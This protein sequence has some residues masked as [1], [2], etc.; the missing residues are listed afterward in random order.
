MKTRNRKRLALGLAFLAP[1]I[2]GF[3]VF[4]LFPLIFSMVLALTNSDLQLHNM[5]KS[6]MPR[7]IGVTNFIRLWQEPDFWRYLGNTLFLMLGIP[8]SIAG[9][10]VAAILLSQDLKGGSRRTWAWVLAGAVM[11]AGFVLMAL[12]G[13]GA[14]A[15]T[16]LIVSV[17]MGILVL[18]SIGG[19]TVYRTLFFT[20]HFTSGVATFI[21]WKK[22]YNPQT[23][24]INGALR[25]VL[26]GLAA[27]VNSLPDA[28]FGGLAWLCAIGVT[29]AIGWG[30][31]WLW[32]EWRDGEAG[33]LGIV[34]G[35]ILL[36]IPAA[37]VSIQHP[38]GTW[39]QGARLRL[40]H[41]GIWQLPVNMSVLV[42]AVAALGLAMLVLALMT[43]K[44]LFRCTRET[45][46]GEALMLGGALMVLQVVL[47]GMVNVFADL[48]S[49]AGDG[50]APPEWL[51]SYGWSKPSLM[52][53]GFWAAVGSNNM[54]LYLAGLSNVPPELHEAAN[55]DGASRF[56]RFW[57]VTWPQLA[58]VTF[59][60]VVM[61][62]IHGLQGGF[63]MARSMTNGGPAGST[64]TL[65][66]YVYTEGFTN[67]RLGFASAI[68]WTLFA[69]VFCVTI[70]NWKFGNRY[71]N[72]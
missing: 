19:N 60:I 66:Y 45:G 10:L 56:Q 63:E 59:F 27:T 52:F 62:I 20:P 24:P 46:L 26:D 22:L 11:V 71:V 17:G 51:T 6:E 14:T 64:T 68:A 12:A 31:R 54:L 29:A 28:L 57:N 43:R 2:T 70:F 67:G 37:F 23:G 21:L 58:P 7:F 65:S 25:P 32:V 18:G 49:M 48:P 4:T 61:S 41:A 42:A 34:Q 30:L 3:L 38:F 36:L 69:L 40:F 35:A 50:L 9:S 33:W 15:T 53:M 44:R 5:F 72:D 1:N 16:M 39:L 47:L 55:I 8:F 13:A